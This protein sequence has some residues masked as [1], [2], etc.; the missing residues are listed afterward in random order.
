MTVYAGHSSTFYD[1]TGVSTPCSAVWPDIARWQRTAED[2]VENHW[3]PQR[4]AQCGKCGEPLRT[5]ESSTVWKMWRTTEDLREQHTVENV[6]NHWGPQRTAQCGKY[7]E[8]LR[9]SESSTMWKMWRTT[10]D[11]RVQHNVE[12]DVGDLREQH[13][14][15]GDVENYWVPVQNILD[16]SVNRPQ[17]LTSDTTVERWQRSQF[18]I[19]LQ[20]Q[21]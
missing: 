15:E 4:T 21:R 8:P 6:E 12:G 16:D 14:V 20:N 1:C 5:S 13:N 7:G 2:A 9:T 19:S 3:G 17:T 10:E 18:T 11:L